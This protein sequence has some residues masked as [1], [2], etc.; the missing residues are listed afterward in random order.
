MMI[1]HVARSSWLRH[2]P[3]GIIHFVTSRSNGPQTKMGTNVQMDG[4]LRSENCLTKHCDKMRRIHICHRRSHK[5]TRKRLHPDAGDR[6]AVYSVKLCYHGA[7][8]ESITTCASNGHVKHRTLRGHKLTENLSSSSAMSCIASM[9]SKPSAPSGASCKGNKHVTN[10]NFKSAASYCLP[11]KQI[12]I[13]LT[14]TKQ[15]RAE[16]NELGNSP[17]LHPHTPPA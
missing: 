9:L 7:A 3:E 17:T 5:H 2:S 6:A 4:R 12:A 16:R 15:L 11:Q 14:T 13:I 8:F 1:K 10:M